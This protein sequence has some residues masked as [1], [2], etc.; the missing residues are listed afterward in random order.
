MLRLPLKHFPL[1]QRLP[2][3]ECEQEILIPYEKLADYLEKA[4]AE[5]L[6]ARGNEG[7]E[8]VLPIGTRK[9][10]RDSTPPETLHMADEERFKADELEVEERA[11]REDPEWEET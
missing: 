3:G 2:A 9:R 11:Q 8:M 6:L 5:V 1:P 7:D 10:K 4:E